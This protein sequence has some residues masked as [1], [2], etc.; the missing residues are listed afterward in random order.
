MTV[1]GGNR[2]DGLSVTFMRTFMRIKANGT[3]DPR[4]SYA[5]AWFGGT[6]GKEV[7]LGGTGKPVIGLTGR[8]G[9]DLDALG[10]VM[11]K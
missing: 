10:V 6:G 11:K 7:T 8:R 9:L 4:D 5:S 1:K 3:L 2:I